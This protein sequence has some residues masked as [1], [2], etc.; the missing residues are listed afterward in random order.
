MLISFILFTWWWFSFVGI[1]CLRSWLRCC[2]LW[3]PLLI[4]LLFVWVVFAVR[5]MV[6]W[7]D[8]WFGLTVPVEFGLTI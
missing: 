7:F 1:W 2:C 4:E 8:G 3:F 6:G 5:W